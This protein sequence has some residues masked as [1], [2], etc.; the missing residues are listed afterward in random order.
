MQA[1]LAAIAITAL[2]FLPWLG[3]ASAALGAEFH[4]APPSTEQFHDA[5]LILLGV[6]VWITMRWV[7]S[8]RPKH[9][10]K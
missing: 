9:W 7:D 4:T 10:R 1:I 3:I 5:S 8:L 2:S 6:A